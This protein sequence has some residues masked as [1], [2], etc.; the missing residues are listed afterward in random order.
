MC[1]SGAPAHLFDHF[2]LPIEARRAALDQRNISG[3][4]HLIH[5]PPCIQIIKR[6]EHNIEALEP[7]NI[8]FWIF[9]ICMVR[10]NLH[11]GIEFPSRLLRNLA[12]RIASLEAVI[13]RMEEEPY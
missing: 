3:Q 7:I 5:M 12:L 11:I 9:Y 8:E 10:L 1:A 6:I 2:H 13:K 4:A